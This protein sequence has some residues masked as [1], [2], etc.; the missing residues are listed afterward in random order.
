METGI[1]R[2]RRR[3][4]VIDTVPVLAVLP[5]VEPPLL[6]GRWTSQLADLSEIF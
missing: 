1:Q 2:S 3:R 5:Q 4:S 6:N